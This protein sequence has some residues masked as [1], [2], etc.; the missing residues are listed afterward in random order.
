M[1]IPSPT[2]PQLPVIDKKTLE[3][4]KAA[5]DVGQKVAAKAKQHAETAKRVAMPVVNVVASS[6]GWGKSIGV[7]DGTQAPRR[8]DYG[9]RKQTLSEFDT[10]SPD[11]SG[12]RLRLFGEVSKETL[13]AAIG[14]EGEAG[15]KSKFRNDDREQTGDAF[16]GIRGRVFA[17]AGPLGGSIG[18]EG[19]AGGEIYS[20][21][22]DERGSATWQSYKS[23]LSAGLR[24]AAIASADAF[25]VRAHALLE[26]GI[27]YRGS[28][29]NHNHLAGPLGVMSTTEFFAFAGARAETS[30][31]LSV[32]GVSAGAEAF[33]GVR[34]G[35][36]QR[37][38][39]AADGTELLGGAIRFEGWAG[40]GVKAK[41]NA[42]LDAETGSF[43]VGA[44]VGAALGIGAG[45]SGGV[46]FNGASLAST[47]R[48]G[49]GG[50][51]VSGSRKP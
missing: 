14:L 48:E 44:D 22:G 51:K 26:A 13:S 36:E 11:R 49:V 4:V 28:T 33:A 46:T 38:A 23:Q 1:K 21:E 7:D 18:A 25:G 10:S 12:A 6:S 34:A 47:A 2:R 5:S 39:L 27:T 42:G 35:L 30:A 3:R 20:Q 9:S 8:F 41:V 17:E 24:G 29:Q 37:F 50:A 19:F 45:V 32:M 15:A 16:A 40:V 43:G 31:G